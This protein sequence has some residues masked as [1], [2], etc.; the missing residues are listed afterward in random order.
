MALP[1]SSLQAMNGL[2]GEADKAE[3]EKLKEVEKELK[4]AE[5]EKVEELR[6]LQERLR[7]LSKKVGELSLPPPMPGAP[8]CAP[9]RIF[10]LLLCFD[11]PAIGTG[12]RSINLCRSPAAGHR[13]A[14]SRK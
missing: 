14:S 2:D 12:Y 4:E 7:I 8:T 3:W 11:V 9:W 5:K 13:L 10:C 1:L 6:L